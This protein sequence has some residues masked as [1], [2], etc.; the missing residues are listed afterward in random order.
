MNIKVSVD[1]LIEMFKDLPLEFEP[2]SQFAYSNSGYVLLGAVSSGQTYSEYLNDYI[3]TPLDMKRSGY[4]NEANISSGI[5]AGYS[6]LGGDDPVQAEPIDMS[7][8][9]AA[10]GIYSTPQDLQKWLQGLESGQVIG[11]ESWLQMRTPYLFDYGMGW[12][13]LQP[14]GTVYGHDGSI[15]GFSSIIQ[16][17]ISKGITV[18]LLSNLQGVQFGEVTQ[19]LLDMLNKLT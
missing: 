5:A 4:L 19:L 3:F 6:I 17:D 14:D 18:I 11:E 15:N 12:F 13:L 1:E 9:Y 16:R 8:A 7:I 2:G 10:G